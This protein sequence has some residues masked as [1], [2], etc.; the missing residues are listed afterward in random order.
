MGISGLGDAITFVIAKRGGAFEPQAR[1]VGL[2]VR[3]GTKGGAKR[4][5]KLRG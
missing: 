5:A 1:Y 2:L 4:A 3:V